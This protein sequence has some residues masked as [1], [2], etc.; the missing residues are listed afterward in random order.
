M[1]NT[2]HTVLNEEQ[3]ELLRRERQLFSELLEFLRSFDAPRNDIE[4]VEQTLGDLEELFL[5]VIVGEFNSGKSAFINSLLGRDIEPEG[6]TPT[7]DRITLLRWAHENYERVRGDG[8]LERGQPIDLLREV[9]IVDTPGTNA[10]I[11]HHEE[12]SKGFVPRSDLVLFVTSVDRPFTESEREYLEIIKEW[13][14][15]LIVIVNK[16][17][18]LSTKEDA[19]NIKEFIQSNM[20]SLLGITPPIFLV[21]SK[22][23]RR[24]KVADSQIERDALYKASGFEELEEYILGILEESNRIRLKLESPLGVA[25]QLVSRYTLG[26]NERMSLLEDD[27]RMTENIDAQLEIYKED[28]QRD[29]SS[30]RAEI[31]N[32]IHQLNERGDKW[33]EENIR[34]GRFFEL[35]KKNE[36]QQ[37]FQK[38]VVGDTTEV[39]DRHIQELV[40]W[41]VDRDLRQWKSIVDYVNR[42]RQATYDHNLIGEIGGNFEYNRNQLLQSIAQDANKVVQSYDREYE[43]S[44]LA[45]SIQSAVAQTVAMEV[46]AVGLGTLVAML[47]TATAV[48]VTGLLAASTIAVLGLFVIPNKRR[49]AR[50]EFRS[51]TEE[52]RQ[53]LIEVLTRQFGLELQRSIER[54]REAIAPYTRFVRSEYQKMS[55]ARDVLSEIKKE[56]EDLRIQIGAPRISA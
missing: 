28:M 9:A 42:R 1:T 51:R 19:E 18:L 26:I 45:L 36:V 10:I 46:G 40:D 56:V 50:N 29:F 30:R 15:K 3:N 49:K 43:A 12:L 4:L 34:I 55:K 13:G 25:D 20:Q 17:D 52:L 38:E 35:V 22:L 2:K 6:V 37:R 47:A 24:A 14:K 5:L 23:A 44:K 27:F 39:I 33:F 32:L 7:T 16:T 21:S 54:I 8:V 48:D 53:K 31:E 41:M 11:R